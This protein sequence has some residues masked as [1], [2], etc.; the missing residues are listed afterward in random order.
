MPLAPAV[1]LDELADLV[2]EGDGVP[3]ALWLRVTP[4]E[5]AVAAQDDAVASGS[6]LHDRAEHHPELEAG[7]LPG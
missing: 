6:V 3:V 2:D 7:A 1:A 4:G 5:E